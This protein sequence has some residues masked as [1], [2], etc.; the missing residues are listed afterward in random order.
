MKIVITVNMQYVLFCS[1][2]QSR[3]TLVTDAY[4]NVLHIF[5]EI[6][7]GFQTE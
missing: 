6:C 7:C 2:Q 4:T 1:N 3:S 5:P